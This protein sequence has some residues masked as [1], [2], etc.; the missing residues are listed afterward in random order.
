[1]KKES[2]LASYLFINK[3]KNLLVEKTILL[4]KS[5]MDWNITINKLFNSLSVD[6]CSL[7]IL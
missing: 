3:E 6:I 1:M 2:H 7:M 5:K 4:A